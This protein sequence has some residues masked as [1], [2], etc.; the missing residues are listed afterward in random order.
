MATAPPGEFSQTLLVWITHCLCSYITHLKK[1]T[2]LLCLCFL[3][4]CQYP[5]I[6][7]KLVS[8]SLMWV[9]PDLSIYSIIYWL[10]VHLSMLWPALVCF[11]VCIQA[12]KSCS[13]SPLFWLINWPRVKN[14]NVEIKAH[15]FINCVHE[16][17]INV[18]KLINCK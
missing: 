12:L 1:Q 16:F 5:C 6:C 11:L 10:L 15:K 17:E 4:V 13:F 14:I 3:N 18:Y 7:S 9:L 2:E 8:G